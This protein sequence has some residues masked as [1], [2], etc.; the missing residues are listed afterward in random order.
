M[1]NKL[2]DFKKIIKFESSRRGDFD[3]LSYKPTF[4]ASAIFYFMYDDNIDTK[5]SFLNYWKIKNF[6]KE[7]SCLFSIRDNLGKNIFRTFIKLKKNTYVFSIKKILKENLGLKKLQ[8]SVNVELFS[9]NDLK[10]IYPAVDAIYE[11]KNGVTLIHSN[12]RLLNEIS[13]KIN[14]ISLNQTQSGFDI[15]N[16]N[17]KYSFV[18]AINGSMELKNRIL[19]ISFF[20]YLGKKFLKSFKF[21]SIKPFEIIRID[22]NKIKKLD[23]FLKNKK[24]FCKIDLPTENIFNRVLVG[25]TSNDN[26]RLTTTH[27]YYDCSNI[28]DF[29]NIK[30]TGSSKKNCYIPFNILNNIDLDIVIY[31]IFSKCN[32]DFD[33]EMYDKNGKRHLIKSNI[34]RITS[35]LSNTL[36]IQ[37]N[38]YLTNIKNLTQNVYSL[39]VKSKNGKIPSRITY[40]FN[41]RQKSFGSNI[42]DAMLINRGS[43]SRGNK[44]KGFYWGPVFNSKKISSII[45]LSNMSSFLKENNQKINLKI[46]NEKNI[47]IKKKYLIKSPEAKNIYLENLFK[48]EKIKKSDDVFWF[49]IESSGPKNLVCKHVHKSVYGHISADH[50]F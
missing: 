36:T 11:T 25:T 43:Q 46:Y 7:V 27:S 4:N 30:E 16:D 14:N 1:K 40:G 31:P 6:N 26:K 29:I 21:K 9:T 19:K 34:L 13:D 5:I 45:T 15:Y 49:T 10:F 37:V 38:K 50:S 35:K 23:N 24:G 22:F 32:L 28:K 8:G 20:N 33:L 47:L 2:S 48:N 42:S 44:S 3:N 17:E 18:V 12:Q 39:T 41:Y